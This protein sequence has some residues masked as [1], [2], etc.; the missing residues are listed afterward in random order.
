MSRI[1]DALKKA[2]G[3]TAALE[4]PIWNETASVTSFPAVLDEKPQPPT[5]PA[6]YAAWKPDMTMLPVLEPGANGVA[7]EEFRRLKGRVLQLR[8]LSPFKSIL[9]GSGLP[10]EGKSFVSTNLALALSRAERRKVLLI[11]GDLRKPNLH[12]VLGAPNSRG[13]AEFLRGEMS[14]QEIQQKGPIANLTFI[15]AGANTVD[16]EGLTSNYRF[17]E[18]MRAVEQE[19]EWIILD[20]SP[21]LPVSD[22]VNLATYCNAVLLVA[23]AAST[24]FEVAQRAVAEFRNSRVIG[25]VLNADK[26]AGRAKD[27][28]YGPYYGGY[29]Q[30]KP[31]N[32][33]FPPVKE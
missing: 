11:D 17:Q 31:A 29:V 26:T 21:V 13:L 20:S 30:N 25:F 1:Y 27:L 2:E 18:L 24:P 7:S 10:G 15:P 3:E 8:E 5:Q 6:E 22:A 9:I 14:L 12:T 32:G 4:S 16:A 33:S 23:R 28:H 19:Y